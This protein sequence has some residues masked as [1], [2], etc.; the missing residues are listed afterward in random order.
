MR[1]YER[2]ELRRSDGSVIS[3]E[4]V[5]EQDAVPVLFCHGLADSRLSAYWFEKAARDLGLCLVAPDRPGTGCSEPLRLRRVA[6][7][8][9]DATLVL[10]ALRIDSA[11]L[12]G[13]SGGGPFAAAW[14]GGLPQ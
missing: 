4:V 14:G 7:W 1:D 12:L 11:A 2:V 6:D 8:V 5:G 13:V 3:V 9:A 10:D